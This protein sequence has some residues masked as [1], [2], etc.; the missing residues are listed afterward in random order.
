MQLNW[1]YNRQLI[2]ETI[3]LKNL[4]PEIDDELDLL[5]WK[6]ICVLEHGEKAQTKLQEEL[7]DHKIKEQRV[8]ALLDEYK[9]KLW[10][11]IKIQ[12]I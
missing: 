7:K 11:I 8:M 4:H 6:I 2:N 12:A 9:D 3:K 5:L 10:D 1:I